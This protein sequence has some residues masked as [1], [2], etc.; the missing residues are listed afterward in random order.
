MSEDEVRQV[1]QAKKEALGVTNKSGMGQLMGAVM[2]ELKGKADG[3]I[4]KKV[5]DEVLS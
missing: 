2:G 4:V 5:V 1:V 3:G